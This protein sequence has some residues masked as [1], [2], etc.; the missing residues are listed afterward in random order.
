VLKVLV[1]CWLLRVGN[2][3][4]SGLQPR[5]R[6]RR[7]PSRGRLGRAWWG[8]SYQCMRSA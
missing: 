6:S 3:L 4:V 8:S 1:W 2:T 7:L 5:W